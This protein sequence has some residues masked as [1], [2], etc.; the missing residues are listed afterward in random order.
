MTRPLRSLLFVPGNRSR[1]VERALRAGADA[2]ILDLEDGVPPDEKDAARSLVAEV[3]K[4]PPGG[5]RLFV[6][7]ASSG[8]APDDDLEEA[9]NLLFDGRLDLLCAIGRGLAGIVVPKVEEPD[10]LPSLERRLDLAEPKIGLEPGSLRLIALIETAK[11]LIAA[12]RIA[13]A[14]PRLMALMF[15]AEDFA[16]DVGMPAVRTRE[17]GDMMYARSALVV[18]AASRRLEAI[19]RVH[20]DLDD[21]AELARDARLAFELGFT[22][23]AAI[24]PKQIAVIH[25]AFRP[26]GE[27]L[28]RARRIVEAFDRAALDGRGTTVVDGR[29]VDRPIAERARRMLGE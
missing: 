11:G 18:A 21:E 10:E 14:S 24:H 5:P 25:D 1:M 20:L 2:V 29:M 17:A 4:R 16:R 22:G 23:K 8:T 26:S 6:R 28:A 19:D 7:I 27:E 12:P 9:R 13:A 15:G 3:T